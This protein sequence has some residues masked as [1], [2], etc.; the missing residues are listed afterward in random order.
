VCVYLAARSQR[1][2]VRWFQALTAVIFWPLFL[3]L[4]LSGRGEAEGQSSGQPGSGSADELDRAIAQVEAE[5]EGALPSLDGWGPPIRESAQRRFQELRSTW[6]TLAG[7]VREM[8]QIIA[9]FRDGRTEGDLLAGSERARDAEEVIRRNFER[10]GQVRQKTLDDLLGLLAQVRELVSL[11]HLARFTSAPA[12]RAEELVAQLGAVAEGISATWQQEP[13][14]RE[15]I[16]RL[17]GE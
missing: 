5:L 16:C 2:A 15:E 14:G 1:P 10:L 13:R 7:R 12:T 17:N 11:I 3:P 9:R 4:L 8:D 6:T